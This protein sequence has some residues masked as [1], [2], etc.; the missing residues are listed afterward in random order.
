M[1]ASVQPQPDNLRRE[2]RQILSA[3]LEEARRKSDFEDL[4]QEMRLG[5]TATRVR[6]AKVLREY[7]TWAVEPLCLAL[8]DKDLNVRAAVAES[9]GHIGD[10][11]AVQP[12]IE[13]LRKCF[14]GRSVYWQFIVGFLVMPFLRH[15]RE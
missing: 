9:L 10:E 11:R 8:Q 14:L 4:L 2:L 6:I 12:L 13:A 5:S 15:Y 3:Q 7:G 1:S